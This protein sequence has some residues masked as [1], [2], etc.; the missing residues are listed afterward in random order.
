M[1]DEVGII[2]KQELV[3]V[4]RYPPGDEEVVELGL[5]SDTAVVRVF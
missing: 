2:I 3:V 5:H 4:N 1:G